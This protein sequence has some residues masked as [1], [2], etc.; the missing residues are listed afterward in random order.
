M[1][2][3]IFAAFSTCDHSRQISPT[4]LEKGLRFRNFS[5]YI[6]HEIFVLLIFSYEVL[7]SKDIFHAIII[8]EKFFMSLFFMRYFSRIFLMRYFSRTFF[9]EIFLKNIFLM[10]YFSRFF[11]DILNLFLTGFCSSTGGFSS[12]LIF[13][14]QPWQHQ[15]HH[16]HQH[17]QHQ[18]QHQQC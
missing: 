13:F 2:S 5:K 4:Y 16:L 17:H 15:H 8:H 10:K 12:S 11:F 1:A 9:N 3:P 7:F 6:F 14:S 18:H